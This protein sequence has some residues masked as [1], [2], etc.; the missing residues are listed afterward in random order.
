MI[1]AE[2]GVELPAVEYNV[3]LLYGVVLDDLPVVDTTFPA[4]LS[5]AEAVVTVVEAASSPGLLMSHPRRYPGHRKP[6]PC[7]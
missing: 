5:A 4:V 3:V 1:D 2:L 6:T 7:P